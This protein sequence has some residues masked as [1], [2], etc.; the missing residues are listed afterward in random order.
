[1]SPSTF[2]AL[3]GDLH[4]QIQFSEDDAQTL[5]ANASETQTTGRHSENRNFSN[6]H[7]STDIS[8]TEAEKGRVNTIMSTLVI[9]KIINDAGTGMGGT[10]EESNRSKTSNTTQMVLQRRRKEIVQNI[11]L[12]PDPRQNVTQVTVPCQTFV[13]GGGLY[14]MQVVR[15]LKTTTTLDHN[16]ANS[17]TESESEPLTTTTLMPSHDERLLQTLDVRWPSAEMIVSPVTLRTYPR[18]SVNVTLRFPE[19]NCERA[20][21]GEREPSL[22]EFWLELVYCG[23]D[24]SCAHSLTNVSKSSVLFAEQVR[25]FPKFKTLQLGCELFGLAGNYAVQLRPMVT[26]LNVPTTRRMIS[27]DWSDEFVFNVYARSI[28]PCDPHSGVG[29]LYEYPGCILEQG[30]RVRLYAKLRADVASL[31]PPTSLHYVAEQRVI[32]SQHSLYFSCELF[33]EKYVE[34]CFVYVSQAISGAVADVRMDCVPTLAVSDSDTGGWGTWSEWTPCSTNCLGGT[35]NRYRFCDSPPPRYGAKFCEKIASEMPPKRKSSKGKAK[36]KEVNKISNVDR[37]FYELQITD[38]NQK[39][40]R[41]RAHLAGLDEANVVMTAKLQD[42][43]HDRTDVAA[44][45]ERTLAE[46]NNSITELE[47]RLVEVSKVRNEENRAAQEKILDLEGKYKAMHDQLTSEIKLLNGKLNS[48]DEF[49]I[50]RDI[51]LAKFDDQESEMKEKEKYHKE[52][53]YNME[54]AAVVEKDALKKEVEAKLLQVS[55]DFTR[56]SEIRNAGYT[57][58]LIRENIALQKEID[59]LVM[60][61][62]KLQQQYNNQKEKHKEIMEQ[63]SALDQIKN[64]LVRNSINKIKIIEGLTHNY[65]T[66]KAKYV[67]ALQY[68]RAYEEQQEAELSVDE[69]NKDAVGKVRSLCRR[70]ENMML[71]KKHLES[72]H[73]QHE[74]EIVRLRGIIQQIKATVRDAIITHQGVTLFPERLEEANVD[75]PHVIKEVR[76]EALSMNKLA[77]IDL[78]TQLMNIVSSHSAE[79]PKTPSVETIGTVTS[80]LYT[81]GKM[82]FMPHKPRPAVCDLFETEVRG[83]LEDLQV[84]LPDCLLKGQ[85]KAGEIEKLGE[86][87]NIFDVELGT[88]LYVSSSREEELVEA[89]EE[90][91][92]EPEGSSST[93]SVKKES[94]EGSAPAPSPLPL[95]KTEDPKMV[96]TKSVQSMT[97]MGTTSMLTGEAEDLDE[98]DE[99]EINLFY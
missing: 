7:L 76:D 26:S 62:I 61:Q 75:E 94:S 8:T 69:R 38:L 2:T 86:R 87:A 35:R 11:P 22:P 32:K 46:R 9:S 88:T 58:R 37:T 15:N 59:L 45:L 39:L 89:D 74:G 65:E 91:L 33:S 83:K 49:R 19:V 30:D 98:E 99:F 31:K 84:K 6:A 92:E 13:R 20:L 10:G 5:K 68:R 85:V 67:E 43:D 55:E 95:A 93:V 97:T 60:S 44:H 4:V 53:L 36:D 18:S 3:S 21:H 28:F 29:V 17:K 82:G 51:L 72:V 50:Q 70:L 27:V 48:L 63:Y 23:K 73:E 96:D 1:M 42:I 47:E 56:S 12:F 90:P 79:L 16:D 34:Y 57:R 54:Q 77:R 40:A 64:E 25:G 14:E 71:E 81:P 80:E 24:R 52:A 78:L 66:L 41:L